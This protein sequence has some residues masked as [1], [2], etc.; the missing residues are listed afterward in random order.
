MNPGHQDWQCVSLP[1]ELS[2]WL[3]N[4]AS[5]T[6]IEIKWLSKMECSVFKPL[7]QGFSD[8][9]ADGRNFL[10]TGETMQAL[11]WETSKEACEI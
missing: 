11:I 8:V 6:R 9:Q 10:D 2:H 5:D 3:R 1:A 4:K 7:A